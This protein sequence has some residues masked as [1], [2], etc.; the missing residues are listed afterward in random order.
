[1]SVLPKVR[2]FAIVVFCCP[3]PSLPTTHS[4]GSSSQQHEIRAYIVALKANTPPGIK[5]NLLE[6]LRSRD[7]SISE[8]LFLAK[9]GRI[10]QLTLNG[11]IA[12]LS[13]TAVRHVSTEVYLYTMHACE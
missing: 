7:A 12:N 2:F 5:E 13:D 6:E 3:N 10:L 11:F 8:P 1:M 4:Q 9:I